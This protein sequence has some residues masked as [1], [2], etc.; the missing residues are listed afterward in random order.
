MKKIF[1]LLTL[2]I[3]LKITATAQETEP[4]NTPAQANILPLNKIDSGAINPGGD[5]DYWKITTNADGK[6]NLYLT[7][8]GGVSGPYLE[9]YLYDKDGTTLINSQRFI[10]T[11]STLSTDGLAAGTYYVEIN[12][13]HTTDVG[14]YILSDSLFTTGYG[15]D[16][17]PN[18]NASQA[19]N[20]PINNTT[21]GHI[22]Y[23]YN[24]QR[25]TT[26]WY[27]VTT[28][29]DGKLNLYFTS[30]SGVNGP[31]LEMYLY[32]KN[33]TIV[34]SSQRFINTTST[35]STDGLA[36]G[37]YYVEI[38]GNHPTD[39][40]PYILSDSLFTTGQGVDKEPNNNAAQADTL[41]LN[42]TTTGH[43]GYYYNNQRDT[44]DWYKVTTNADGEL[45]LYLTSPDG[46][47]G[48]YLEM[49]LYDKDGTTPIG[50][51]RFINTTSILSTDGLAEGTYYVE[52]VGYH[53]E[54]F[55]PY[56]LSDSLFTYAYTADNQAE[57]NGF[58]S[59]AKTLSANRSTSGH[60]GFYYNNQRDTTDW[61]KINYTGTSGNLN[62]TFS[63]LPHLIDGSVNFV[64]FYVYKDTS[65]SPIYQATF[66]GE[67]SDNINL[68]G[69]TQ[70]YYYIEITQYNSN[71]FEAYSITDSFTQVNVAAI[72][73]LKLASHNTCGTDSLTYDL[74]G[75][76]APYIVRL[77]L[78]GVLYDSLTTVSDSAV[79]P[80]LNDGN[81]YATVYGDGATDSAYGKTG[82][83]Q[84]LP[85]TPSGL[86]ATNIGAHGAT[87]NF[88]NL[89]C[90]TD[91]V[92]QYKVTGT[93]IYTTV[94]VSGINGAYAL[95][96]LVTNTMYTFRLASSDPTNGLVSAYSD[97]ATFTTLSD[98]PVTLLNFDGVLQD[99]KAL[100]SWST[101]QEINNKGFEVEKSYDGQT[102]TGIGF[103]NGAGNSSVVNNYHYTDFKVQSGSN[104]YR[105]KQTDIDDNFNYSSIIRLDFKHFSWAI[106]GNPV[107]SNSWIQLQL[108]KTSNVAIQVFSID[109]KII[110]SINKGNMPGGTYSI[111][112][113]LG[114]APAGIYIIRLLTDGGNFSKKLIK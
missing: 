100:F 86:S 62:L 1:T 36:A 61:W 91:Y 20:L 95:A 7:S 96:G 40:G 60:F 33:G 47:N 104:Y 101:S 105:L 112:L 103:V 57:P 48:P 28:N 83:T 42:N 32:D 18:N 14:P 70:G 107:T 44:T 66:H 110:K 111:P 94:D 76:L 30:P 34:I 16:A 50:N 85:V 25:D 51:K 99:T 4:N 102:F 74:S 79:F 11:T 98:L 67:T 45:N 3:L 114:D 77:Y 31:Y 58:A 75:S 92:I 41:P 84:F 55:A 22:G 8:P 37:T 73:L 106:F 87:L 78:N 19:V 54:N 38:D 72:N 29:A 59:Q 49:Y 13:N 35:L 46:V 71:D 69:L 23:Y 56:V 15:N 24:N 81:Y 2:V 53:P 113:N 93:S 89:S 26:D 88:T 43:I 68:T 12:G 10:N 109:G 82:I 64:N 9:M 6:L 90:E 80:G 27:K 65:A 97:T 52:I 39:F 17:E 5:V 21:T 63:H 108:T